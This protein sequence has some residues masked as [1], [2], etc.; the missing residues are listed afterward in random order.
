MVSTWI[1]ASLLSLSNPV[2]ASGG[3]DTNHSDVSWNTLETE[4]FYFHWPKSKRNTDDPHYFTTEFTVRRLSGI[5]EESYDKICSQ[6][7]FYPKEKI[8]VVIYDQDV[9]WEGNGFAIAELD[10]TGFA[11]D[12]GPLF[13]MRGRMEFLSDVFVHE[14]AH[15][16][17]L[18]AYLPWSESSTAVEFGGLVE[19]EEWIRRWGYKGNA[20]VNFDVGFSGLWS[21]HAPFWWAEGGAEYWSHNAGYNFW[22]G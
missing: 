14:F 20:S 2:L 12:W 1:L 21:P 10:W 16:V 5:A 7:D 15:I 3:F 4:H 11:A 9:G 8:H 17:S 22:G 18:K 19:D 6:L 13:R